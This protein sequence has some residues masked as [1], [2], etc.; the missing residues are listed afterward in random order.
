MEK[1]TA[2]FHRSHSAWKTRPRTSS[3]PQFPQPLRLGTFRED[4]ESPKTANPNP[5]DAIEK[6][7]TGQL[8]AK[9]FSTIRLPREFD[10][11]NVTFAAN[12]PVG[13]KPSLRAG[14]ES[15]SSGQKLSF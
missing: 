1:Q 15:Q 11:S 2:F 9:I 12:A 5:F 8:W 10:T 7:V 4:Q 6:L 3:F 13:L 14:S